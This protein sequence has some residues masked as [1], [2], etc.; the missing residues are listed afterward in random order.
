MTKPLLP[1]AFWFR[2]A[3]SCPRVEPLPATGPR[4]LLDLPEAA[5]IPDLSALEG[6]DS[7]ASV[8]VGWS[9][10]G[11]GVAV[12][13]DGFAG[14]LPGPVAPEKFADVHLWIDTR[15]TRDVSRATRFCHRFSATLTLDK[16]RRTLRH[17]LAQRPIARAVADAPLCSPGKLLARCGLDRS[18][19]SLEV[20]FPTAVLNGFDPDTNRRLGF[21][22][23]VSDYQRED[24]FLGVGRDFPL[25][26]NPSL[27][28]T[29]ELAP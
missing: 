24:Q 6:R 1:Q 23:Q 21:A 26:E 13:S 19:W 28:A 2:L 8:R 17:E 12:R 14:K 4:S 11:L 9:P 18:G 29:L 22:Y 3:A 27:W 25:G 15:D 20:F 10:A 16:D 5:A 7:W